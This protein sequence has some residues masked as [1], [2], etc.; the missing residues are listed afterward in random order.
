MS[1]QRNLTDRTMEAFIRGMALCESDAAFFRELVHFNQTESEQEKLLALE[2]LRG[3]R[4]KVSQEIIPL[5]L[6]EY[7]AT[8]YFPVVR[9]LACLLDWKGNFKLLAQT[10]MPPIKKAEA[11][12]AVTF[13]LK[14][15]F[16]TID[17]AGKYHQKSPA[18]STGSEVSSL[19][20]RAFNEMMVKRGAEAIR[21]FPPS[22][23]DVRTV[24]VGASR[25]C[26]SQIKEEIRAFVARVVQLVDDDPDSDTVYS[27][28]LQLFPL[29]KSPQ[30]GVPPNENP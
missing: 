13:L 19:A 10:V 30:E 3:L 2:R 29:S 8:W 20:L 24:I 1:G 17:E 26:Y 16:L 6:Y 12:A 15:G 18:L 7:F 28:S 11:E 9:E 4:R 5:D 22:E 14:K 25:K 21:Q 23:R 27:L